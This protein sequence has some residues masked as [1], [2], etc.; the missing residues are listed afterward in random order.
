[1]NA[2]LSIRAAV[3]AGALLAALPACKKAEAP[4]P[5]AV[6]KADL[7]RLS[8]GE[9][10]ALAAERRLPVFWSNDANGNGAPDP[11]ELVA[12]WGVGGAGGLGEMVSDG[13]FTPEFHAAYEALVSAKAGTAAPADAAEAERQ[14]LVRKELAQGRPTLLL[15]DFRAA[16]AEDKA[17]VKNI[18]EAAVLIEEIYAQ[19]TGAAAWAGKVPAGDAAS[20]MMFHRNQG[21]WCVA[22]ATESN[23][24]CSAVPGGAEKLSG[25][26]PAELQKTPG[27]CEAL[28]Q[29]ADGEALL[30]QFVVVRGEGEA[31]KA[32]PYAEAYAPQMQLISEKLKGAAAAIQSEGEAPFKAYLLAAAQAFLDNEWEPADEAWSKMNVHNS[33]W[34]LRIGPDEV[35]FEPCNRKAGFH[36]SFARINPDS[37]DWQR[38]LEPERSEMESELARL[39]GRPYQAREVS[40][41]LPDFIDIIVNAGD[42]RNAHGATIGQSLPN[43]GKVVDEG[44]GRTVAMTNLYT[45]Q[46]SKDELK[47][48]AESLLCASAMA[49]F[50][51]DPGAQV[52]STVLHEAAHNLGPAHDYKVDGKTASQVF[53]GPLAS[54]LEE[55]KSQTAALYFTHWL[56]AKELITKKQAHEAHTRDVIWG[57]GH[58]SR[59]MYDAAGKPKSYSQLAAIQLGFLAKKGA[60]QW[61][62]EEKAANGTDV[63]CFALDL[64]R[65]PSATTELMH[66]VAGVKSRGDVN[67][68]KALIAEHVD[69]SGETK[70]RMEVIQERWLRA[71]KASFVYAVEL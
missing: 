52:M 17:I 20:Q 64:D 2:N 26:Y 46:D 11:G 24:K 9:F 44:R 56:A 54:T 37:L 60:V 65:F 67:G 16:S 70:A 35:Y 36:V 47:K 7:S 27:F 69:A 30:H 51:S 38:K 23:P 42:A 6:A 15:N 43:W 13:A 63:G 25:L 71:P 39:A 45:D 18:L 68:A 48:Q 33:K 66:I 28:A 3:A 8:R 10:N 19:Q 1:M 41:H 53:G 22:P 57:F 58:I 40:F 61:R 14:A 31:L 4:A 62:A 29:R 49:S 32:V 12:L 5:A 55:L 34:Y 50:T 21:P 59:G